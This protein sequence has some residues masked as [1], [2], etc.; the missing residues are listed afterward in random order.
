[1]SCPTE[2][3]TAFVDGALEAPEQAQIEQHLLECGD[4]R[5]QADFE[6]SLRGRLA[7]LPRPA[8]PETLEARVRAALRPA[9]RRPAVWRLLLPAAAVLAL[10]A[11]WGYGAP[12]V[13][14]TQ[15]AWDHGHCFGKEKLPAA[16]WTGDGDH[17]ASWLVAQGTATPVLPPRAGGLEMMGGRRCPL[18]GRRVGHVYYSSGEHRLSVFVVPGWVR[19]DR[20]RQARRGDRTVRLLRMGG[21]TVGVVSEEPEAVEAFERAL[22][23]TMVQLRLTPAAAFD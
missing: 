2:K 1:V 9:R 23:T 21:A 19:L 5:A 15:L 10:L 20:T 18:L 7:A 8:L 11:V 4:C 3:V 12:G 13:L 6:R 16:V 17:M 22:T 14:A